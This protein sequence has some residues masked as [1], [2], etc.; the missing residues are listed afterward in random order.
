MKKFDVIGLKKYLDKAG[1]KNI[2][3]MGDNKDV[4]NVPYKSVSGGLDSLQSNIVEYGK[5]L[6]YTKATNSFSGVVLGKGELVMMTVI[7]GDRVLIQYIDTYTASKSVSK[8]SNSKLSLSVFAGVIGDS[9]QGNKEVKI[10]Y[11]DLTEKKKSEIKKLGLDVNVVFPLILSSSKSSHGNIFNEESDNNEFEEQQKETVANPQIEIKYLGDF[12]N[13]LHDKDCQKYTHL[14][15]KDKIKD[16]TTEQLQAYMKL[17]DK[18]MEIENVIYKLNRASKEILENRLLLGSK[19]SVEDEIP[20]ANSEQNYKKKAEDIIKQM[21]GIN[22]LSAMTGANTFIALEDGL[23]FKFKGCKQCNYVKITVNGKD[24]YDL[25]FKN[26]KG[27]NVKDFK[28]ERD[29]GVENLKKTFTKT[30]GL[31]LY[32]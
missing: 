30:T 26:I 17:T 18:A 23:S 22:K 3:V 32:I 12:T 29:V 9:E 28:T 7:K 16:L 24:L 8:A 10:F 20:L 1:V 13:L 14:E 2:E 21:G 31:D 25:D 6:G 19:W 11:N 15:M 27:M 5:E 4:L